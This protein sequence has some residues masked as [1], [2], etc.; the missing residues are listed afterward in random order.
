MR[1]IILFCLLVSAG[2]LSAQQH[3]SAYL[4][5]VKAYEAGDYSEYLSAMTLALEKNPEHDLII[6]EHMKALVL[7][8]RITEALI[9][10]SYLID[11][12]SITV[13]GLYENKLFE[14]V[15]NVGLIA[16]IRDMERPIVNSDTV[17]IITERD[18]ILEGIAVDSLTG[19]KFIGS[20]HKEKVVAVMVNGHFSDFSH[21]GDS[22]WSFLG[23]EVDEERGVLWAAT[24]YSPY[25]ESSQN[26]GCSKLV[27]LNLHTGRLIQ[28]YKVCNELLNDITVA[29]NGDV[30]ATGTIGAKLY[31]F[32]VS[33]DEFRALSDFSKEG[34]RFLNGIAINNETGRL[35][36][37]H[38]TG[39]LIRDLSSGE[40]IELQKPSHISLM[41]I[42]GMTHYRNSLICHQRMLGSI[43]RYLLSPNGDKVI[44]EEIID[45]HHPAFDSPTT[46]ELGGDGYY[47][48]LANSQITSAYTNGKLKAYHNLQDKIILRWKL[49]ESH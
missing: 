46:G 37:A 47:Y 22:L 9:Q 12:R 39:V 24:A 20:T 32:D 35:Y 14:A 18:L 33:T 2:Q 3:S 48:Y 44:G 13:H 40:F 6:F 25:R 19:R 4:K 27:R 16:R 42:D 15:L 26:S 23:M 21:S 29:G 8:D 41:G 7:N 5:G 34:Y 43:T 10:L 49:P 45:A 17:N 28:S 1:Y 38:E 31:Q 30:F 36:V 11:R